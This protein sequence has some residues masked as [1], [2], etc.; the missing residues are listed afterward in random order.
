MKTIKS[1]QFLFTLKLLKFYQDVVLILY[2]QSC[3]K[4]FAFLILYLLSITSNSFCKVAIVIIFYYYNISY[5]NFN[6]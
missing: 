2:Y 4:L 1:T 6:L 3:R 5:N